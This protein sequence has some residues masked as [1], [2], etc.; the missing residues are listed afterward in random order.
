[1]HEVDRILL[2]MMWEYRLLGDL[3]T[4]QESGKGLRP[5]EDLSDRS[6]LFDNHLCTD[7]QNKE[8]H[9][10]SKVSVRFLDRCHNFSKNLWASETFYRA[11]A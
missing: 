1:M 5:H 4:L 8:N 6:S 11:L 3:N 2:E 7:F 10:P 9:V